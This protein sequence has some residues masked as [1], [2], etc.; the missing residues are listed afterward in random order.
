MS[1]P[2]QNRVT[3]TGEFIA[4]QA[5]GTMFGNRGGRIHNRAQNIQRKWANKQWICCVLDFKN[6]QRT[7]MGDSYTELFFLDEATALAAG[8]R[9]C[10]ECRR[11]DALTFST[12]WANIRN[13]ETRAKVAEMDK[14]LHAERRAPL[15][16]LRL[17]DLPDNTMFKHLENIYLNTP[18]GAQK[19]SFSGYSDPISISGEVQAITPKSI[20]DILRAGYKP[21]L[22]PTAIL[23]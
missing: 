7:I 5:R 6:R 20:R 13:R 18:K 11:A 1:R 22:H 2:L 14:V 9:P 12:H 19:W 23:A 17:Q 8:H 21:Q 4:T 15:D 3:P 16:T 10:F